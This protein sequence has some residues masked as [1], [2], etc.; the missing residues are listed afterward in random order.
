MRYWVV[1][2]GAHWP[3]PRRYVPTASLQPPQAL[4]ALDWSAWTLEPQERD[5][6]LAALRAYRSQWK[7]MEPFLASFVRTNELF[8]TL[9]YPALPATPRPD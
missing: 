3:A 2:G 9:A 7:I 4:Q 5:A 8:A 6:K 1:H